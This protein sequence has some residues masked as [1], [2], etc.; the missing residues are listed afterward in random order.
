MRTLASGTAIVTPGAAG[1]RRRLIANS[2]TPSASHSSCLLVGIRSSELHDAILGRCSSAINLIRSD[3]EDLVCVFAARRERHV[4]RFGT[5]S[6]A[7][8]MIDV[9]LL[10][11]AFCALECAWYDDKIIGTH[12]IFI[13]QVAAA[14]TG[15]GCTLFN[16]ERALRVLRRTSLE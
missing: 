3:E 13:G 7:Q 12:R 11:Q 15:H 6:W 4:H 10:Y 1:G 5:A 9:P 14:R 8:G 16:F 2:M